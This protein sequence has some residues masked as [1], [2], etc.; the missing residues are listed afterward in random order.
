MQPSEIT[1][2]SHA[3]QLTEIERLTK[4]GQQWKWITTG[5][6]LF[7]IVSTILDT[8]GL[9][10]RWLMAIVY[11]STLLLGIV[12]MGS[13]RMQLRTWARH[14]QTLIKTSQQ[15]APTRHNHQTLSS[16]SDTVVD[17]AQFATG[18]TAI[19]SI[20]EEL[21]GAQDEDEIWRIAVE[22]TRERLGAERCAIFW[23]DEA[24]KEWVG[25]YGTDFQGNTTLEHGYRFSHNE[26]LTYEKGNGQ[27]WF[28]E[29]TGPYVEYKGVQGPYKAD[30][31]WIAHTPI[32]ANGNSITALM[33][34][35]SFLTRA[36]VNTRQQ[37]LIAVFC[38]TLG[39]IVGRKRLES[40]LQ[41][42]NLK[43]EQRVQLR[44]RQLSR[45]VE[46]ERL[47]TAIASQFMRA[48]ATQINQ[49]IQYA[50]SQ[51]AQFL[52]VQISKIFFLAPDGY[53]LDEAFEW[54]AEGISADDRPKY[55]EPF[56]QRYPWWHQ[57]LLNDTAIQIVSLDQLPPEMAAFVEDARRQNIRSMVSVPLM[58]GKDLIGEMGFDTVGIERLWTHEDITLIRLVA[59][60]ISGAME[61][62][63]IARAL[64]T[65][66][67]FLEL[68]VTERTRELTTL[69]EMS[70][71]L[72]AA[73][74]M[75]SLLER[76]MNSLRQLLQ[77][78]YM[79]VWERVGDNEMRLV[80]VDEHGPDSDADGSIQDIRWNYQE[81]IDLHWKA[82][83]EQRRFVIIA[84]VNDVSDYA[85]AYR[86]QTLRLL[87]HVPK[88]IQS[89][90][91]VPILSHGRVLGI[92][93][94]GNPAPQ[95][96][97][98]RHAQLVMA[99]AHQ[100]GISIDNARMHSQ[101]IKSAAMGER[102][103]LARELHDSVSQALF[104]I[105]L[106]ARTLK[107]HVSMYKREYAEAVEYLL[108]LS[109][110]SLAEMRA[111]IFEL[112][113]ES[114]EKFGLIEA[115]RKQATELCTRHDLKLQMEA[116]DQDPALPLAVKEAIYRVG[117]EALQ[118]TIKH[119]QA[120][121]VSVR[122]RSA[123]AHVIIEVTDDGTGFDQQKSYA[124][125]L[126]L[127]TMRERAMEFGGTLHLQSAVG[128]G[129]IVQANFPVNMVKSAFR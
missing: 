110:V 70:Q 28:L 126:G 31:G 1:E 81:E 80:N 82:V 120:K 67:D 11:A 113:P 93:V 100:I 44:T 109:E 7:A 114:L 42:S 6:I 118:N 14:A 103:R 85:E 105:V 18:L 71:S 59:E 49:N 30:S 96:F 35:D 63:R 77:Y 108:K 73:P 33:F 40:S 92:M 32:F 3:D 13:V 68:R 56:Y 94:V 53:I 21:L 62:I 23:F 124:G 95:A 99:L 39:S 50:M 55:S 87:G 52:G 26:I 54:R 102:N 79:M 37:N 12:L 116:D 46:S 17:E 8:V 64:Q 5:L 4:A 86:A 41:D 112:R 36:S 127:H 90:L 34:N 66:R 16:G 121:T 24:S 107:Q 58:R 75:N 78:N 29:Q 128:A 51:I 19:F 129:T 72:S 115:F 88:T 117:M 22:R 57:Q 83:L 27:H 2:P 65:E 76:A 89:L 9:F 84:D 119:A 60:T 38:S 43:L 45:Q 98:E 111:L 61:R 20:T 47:G 74:D 97:Q 106:G 69:L 15:Q 125:H 48:D 101:Q 10:P 104:G 122:L 91:L 123:D 25:T